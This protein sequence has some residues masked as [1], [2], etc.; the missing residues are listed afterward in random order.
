MPGRQ[1]RNKEPP[2]SRPQSLLAGQILREAFDPAIST[3]ISAEQATY[4]TQLV[5]T[6][7]EA[8]GLSQVR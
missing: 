2:L 3:K 1:T 6:A 5:N 7:F 4:L 8:K